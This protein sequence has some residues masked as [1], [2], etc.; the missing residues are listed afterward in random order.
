MAHIEQKPIPG[1]DN[2]DSNLTSY[3]P[4]GKQGRSN[5]EVSCDYVPMNVYID[6]RTMKTRF[7]GLS[8]QSS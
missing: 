5:R 1:T 4:R 2:T 3:F 6:P 7:Q 8:I